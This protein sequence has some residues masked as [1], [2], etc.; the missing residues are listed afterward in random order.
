MEIKAEQNGPKL[1][2]E[3]DFDEPEQ[4]FIFREEFESMMNRVAKRLDGIVI[5]AETDGSLAKEDIRKA[6]NETINKFSSKE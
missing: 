1:R 3:V 5:G 4:S 6:F 2:I